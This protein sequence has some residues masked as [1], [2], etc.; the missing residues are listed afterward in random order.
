MYVNNAV[1][2]FAQHFAVDDTRGLTK[3]SSCSSYR[4]RAISNQVVTNSQM[5]RLPCMKQGPISVLDWHACMRAWK[6][7]PGCQCRLGLCSYSGAVTLQHPIHS[8]RQDSP[9]KFSNLYA[10]KSLEVTK[11]SC[12]KLMSPP[13][14]GMQDFYAGQIMNPNLPEKVRSCRV[15]GQES[16][17]C[18]R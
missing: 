16:F 11:R 5:V 18:V 13:L 12:I 2:G 17:S 3:A 1:Q 14:S 9:S 7:N 10:K 8:F 4:A 15:S 6:P